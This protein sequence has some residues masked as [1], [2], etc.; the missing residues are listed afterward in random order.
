MRE[1]VDSVLRAI[2]GTPRNMPLDE[3]E[4]RVQVLE[5]QVEANRLALQEHEAE[6]HREDTPA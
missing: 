6:R 1:I 4:A 5:S 3:V 2:I